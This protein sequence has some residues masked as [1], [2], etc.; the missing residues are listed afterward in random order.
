MMIFE[1]REIIV[2][3]SE[4]GACLRLKHVIVAGVV[5]VVRGRGE[6][7]TQQVEGGR[8]AQVLDTPRPKHIVVDGLE[9]VRCVDRVVVVDCRVR[10]TVGGLD[11]QGELL[12]DLR[13]DTQLLTEIELLEDVLE[14]KVE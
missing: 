14:H 9:H 8:L 11:L 4:L 7:Q 3:C 13:V 5:E 1:Y 10:L 2:Q 12:V 6:E